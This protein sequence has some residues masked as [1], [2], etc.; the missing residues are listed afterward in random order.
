VQHLLDGEEFLRYGSRR[1]VTGQRFFSPVIFADV[2]LR[3]DPGNGT[4]SL[5]YSWL[6]GIA[7]LCALT[8]VAAADVTKSQSNSVTARISSLLGAEHGALSALPNAT[9]SK[10]VGKSSTAAVPVKYSDDWV[11][12]QPVA[13]GGEEWSCLA[14]AL[15]FEAR[16]ET[17][18]G[19]F[20]VAEVILNRV[21]SDRYPDSVC[22]VVNQ[23]TGRKHAC[24][25]SF[26]CDGRADKI[27]EKD[28]YA[29]VAKIA[30]VMLAGGPRALTKGATH[31]HTSQVRPGWAHSFPRTATIG[32]HLFYRQPS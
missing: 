26:A 28:A 17:V 18:K 22:G 25:F 16:G 23:G 12:A 30:K 20:A 2:A 32:A 11:D 27:S 1:Y 8:G 31:F 24:Q 4:M 19:Q 14:K 15:Y 3:N 5:K 13:R 29:H 7:M 6:G 10:P 21:D 9:L